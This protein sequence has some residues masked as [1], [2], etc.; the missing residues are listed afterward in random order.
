MDTCFCLMQFKL[1]LHS[2]YG[3]AKKLPNDWKGQGFRMAQIVAYLV[4]THS[5]PP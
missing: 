1:E 2:C 4:K 5:L 3:H